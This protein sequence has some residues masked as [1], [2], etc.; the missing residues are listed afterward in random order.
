VGGEIGEVGTENSTPE[1]LRAYMD[2]Y[3]ASWRGP[4]RRGG[5]AAGRALQD[6]R[7]VRHLA[8]RVVLP[9]GSIAEVAIDF[10]T[11]RTPLDHRPRGV[12][13]L[14]GGAARRL[15]PAGGRVRQL[16]GG[17]DRRD[18][19][20]HQLPEHRLRAPG[21]AGGAARADVRAL[22][23]R[24]SATSG[25]PGDT[26]EQFIYKTR[27]KA[28]GA[29][30]RELWELP[31]ERRAAIRETLREQFAF[32]FRELR[33][34]NTMEMVRRHTTVREV[35]RAGPADMRFQAAADDWDLSD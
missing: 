27:K 16:P 10:E 33:V 21:A 3:G 26:E 17:G 9:D 20:G 31:E 19:P 8:R 5:R 1:E 2:G 6:L 25:R 28:L 22:P 24:A 30:K 14:R 4:P 35:E 29:F 12:R 32:L 15:H 18:P 13:P 11:L 23:H 34:E 7:P